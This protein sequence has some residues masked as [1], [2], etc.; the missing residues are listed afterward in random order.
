MIYRF[1]FLYPVL[2]LPSDHF[3]L[4]IIYDFHHFRHLFLFV[5]INKTASAT[6]FSLATSAS[7]TNIS[8]ILTTTS[9]TTFSLN[10]SASA[11]TFSFVDDHFRFRH[12]LLVRFDDHFHHL[13]LEYDYHDYMKMKLSMLEHHL[14]VS[15]HLEIKR[16]RTST[17][18]EP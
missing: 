17:F 12:H 15:I 11:T 8:F 18:F 4:L 10:T 6:T 3:L 14:E 13:L 5:L 9:A 1:P 7:A 16:H 2:A